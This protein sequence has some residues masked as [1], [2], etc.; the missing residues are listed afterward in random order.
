MALPFEPLPFESGVRPPAEEAPH[1]VPSKEEAEQELGD[2]LIFLKLSGRLF[3]K[4]VCMISW[5]CKHAGVGGV[6]A[7]FA[8][9]PGCKETGHYNRHFTAVLAEDRLVEGNYPLSVPSHNKWD[10]E[11]VSMDLP[12]L[13]LH[14]A[15]N[16]EIENTPGL[17]DKLSETVERGEWAESYR[18]HTVVT[19]AA[20]GED[21]WP[22][23]VCCDTLS[24]HKRV[25]ALIFTVCNLVCCTRHRCIAVCSS[26]LCKCGCLGWCTLLSSD[27][28]H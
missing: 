23:T 10:D 8:F 25:S 17:E 2:M 24:I 20:E 12:T 15:L 19:S 9:R 4:D 21:V 16:D 22:L 14:E 13:P 5:W 1:D 28:V 26:E 6:T 27:V 7:D 18:T 11:D 3:A